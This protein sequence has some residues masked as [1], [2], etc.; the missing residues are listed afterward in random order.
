QAAD[1]VIVKRLELLVRLAVRP[2]R[3]MRRHPG[4]GHVTEHPGVIAKLEL[5]RIAV[6]PELGGLVADAAVPFDKV[7]ESPDR[8]VAGGAGVGSGA[9]ASLT[10]SLARKALNEGQ[11]SSLRSMS[12]V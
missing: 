8:D 1:A 9:H 5:L 4:V 6:K 7:V 2:V 12:T 3:V 10:R 11:M